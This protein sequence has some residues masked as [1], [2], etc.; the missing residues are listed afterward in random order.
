MLTNP[1]TLEASSEIS[2]L[3][4]AILS[5]GLGRSPYQRYQKPYELYQDLLA[6]RSKYG[7]M[8]STLRNTLVE[9]KSQSLTPEVKSEN[10]P[11]DSLASVQLIKEELENSLFAQRPEELPLLQEGPD[12]RNAILW[13]AA[14][15]FCLAFFLVQRILY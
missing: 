6:A 1:N 2:P 7:N 5:K 13:F 4:R 8:S 9:E 14:M 3:F 10:K 11:E 12:M 15:L